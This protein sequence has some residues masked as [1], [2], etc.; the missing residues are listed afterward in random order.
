MGLQWVKER[1]GDDKGKPSE[2]HLFTFVVS[3][4]ILARNLVMK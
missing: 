2:D 1:T 4:T 3:V